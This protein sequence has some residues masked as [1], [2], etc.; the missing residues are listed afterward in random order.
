MTFAELARLDLKVVHLPDGYQTS[1]W[2]DLYQLFKQRMLEEAKKDE[3][4]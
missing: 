3:A 2:E 1:F 4:S